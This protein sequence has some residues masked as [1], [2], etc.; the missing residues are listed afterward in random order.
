MSIYDFV[1]SLLTTRPGVGENE[2]INVFSVSDYINPDLIKKFELETKIDVVYD[3]YDTNETMYQRLLTNSD[4]YDLVIP[5][6]YTIEKMIKNDMHESAYPNYDT[7]DNCEIFIDLGD[8]LKLYD[9][10]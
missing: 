9:E 7:L 10:A 2:T 5:S 1:I 4:Q 6:D 3:Y 8:N